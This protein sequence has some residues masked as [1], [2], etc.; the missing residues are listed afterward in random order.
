MSLLY[1]YNPRWVINVVTSRKSGCSFSWWHPH[2]RSILEN[3]LLVDNSYKTLS[4]VVIY[5]FIYIYIYIT[6]GSLISP[7]H[8]FTASDVTIGLGTMTTGLT[9]GVKGCTMMMS[10]TISY[11]SLVLTSFL[12]RP[13]SVL[14]TGWAIGLTVSFMDSF[15]CCP[16]SFPTPWKTNW[17]SSLMSLYDCINVLTWANWT[18]MLHFPSSREKR[19]AVRL[20]S[21]VLLLPLSQQTLFFPLL[22]SGFNSGSKIA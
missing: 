11:G 6:L 15:T 3:I 13:N 2:S 12:R 18:P 19:R 14:R 16:F 17:N 1:Q 7:M 5:I 20:D 21:K 9:H 4:T 22:T 8:V 10:R